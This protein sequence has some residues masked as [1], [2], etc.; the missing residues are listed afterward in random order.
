[1]LVVSLS[2]AA[3]GILA[4]TAAVYDSFVPKGSLLAFLATL[5]PLALLVAGII[6]VFVWLCER[7]ESDSERRDEQR[8]KPRP[9]D[10]PTACERRHFFEEIDRRRDASQFSKMTAAG[11]R[12]LG[13]VRGLARSRVTSA[14]R[15][16]P[17]RQ[18]HGQ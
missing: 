9:P 11:D 2:M 18:W 1:M 16:S 10:F 15:P 5:L 13:G 7:F 3:A 14:R 4:C 8:L 12:Y 17:A 6:A